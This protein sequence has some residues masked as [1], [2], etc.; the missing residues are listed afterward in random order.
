MNNCENC[1][2]WQLWVEQKHPAAI[3]GDCRK[4]A[5]QNFQIQKGQPVEKFITKWPSTRNTDFCGD[6]KPKQNP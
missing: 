3:V 2:Y 6:H 4:S 5:P 1:K